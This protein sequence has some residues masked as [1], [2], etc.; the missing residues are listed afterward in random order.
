MRR[1]LNQNS[2]TGNTKLDL[3]KAKAATTATAHNSIVSPVNSP[4]SQASV[5]NEQSSPSSSIVTSPMTNQPEGGGPTLYPAGHPSIQEV[6]D[7]HRQHSAMPVSSS[8][9]MSFPPAFDM[10]DPTLHAR[11]APGSIEGALEAHAGHDIQSRFSADWSGH[12]GIS[13]GK[14]TPLNFVLHHRTLAS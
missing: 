10:N 12:C 3:L 14:L 9:Q 5:W 13:S 7:F 11:P 8:G 4:Q 1:P 6:H 2:S